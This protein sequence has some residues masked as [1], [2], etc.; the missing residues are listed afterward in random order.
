MLKIIDAD[1]TVQE[2]IDANGGYCPCAI[3]QNEDTLCPC[4]EFRTLPEPSVCHC[5]RFEK[6]RENDV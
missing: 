4:F 6:V 1:V 3:Y 5:G 2:A